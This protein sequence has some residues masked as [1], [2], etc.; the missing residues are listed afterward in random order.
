MVAGSEQNA[1]SGQFSEAERYIKELEDLEDYYFNADKQTKISTIA[2]KA[3]CSVDQALATLLQPSRDVQVKGL[4]LKGRAL[5]FLIGRESESE[6]SLSKAIKLDPKHLASWNALGEVHWNTQNYS[7]ARESFEHALEFCGEN[8]VS[9][10]NLSMVLRALDGGSR[11]DDEATH[12]R[13]AENVALALEKA[14]AA[15]ALDASDPQNWETLGNS[16]VGDFFLNARRPDELSRALIAYSKAE[17]AYE[18]LGK[19]NPSLQLNRGMAARYMEDYDLAL[20][21]FRKAH[22]IGMPS[23]A[24]EGQ[25][26]MELVQRLAGSTQRKGDLKAKRLKELLEDFDRRG[27]VQRTLQDVRTGEGP[28]AAPLAARVVVIIDRNDDL[29]VIVLCCDSNGDFFALSVYNAKQSKVADAIVPMKTLLHIHQPKYREHSVTSSN[30][31]TLSYPCVRVAHPGDVTVVGGGT[32]ASAAVRSKFTAAAFSAGPGA[33]VDVALEAAD[34]LQCEKSETTE[35]KVSPN[36]EKWIDQEDA[37]IKKLEAKA[38]AKAAAKSKPKAKVK[39]NKKDR[40]ASKTI[41]AKSQIKAAVCLDKVEEPESDAELETDAGGS[42]SCYDLDEKDTV[43]CVEDDS[44]DKVEIEDDSSD[45][46]P[47][48]LRWSEL[49]DSEDDGF[50]PVQC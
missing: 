11:E 28:K 20:R 33:A 14:K 47:Q 12:A 30:K 21:S 9:L 45:K 18:K 19:S 38:K 34:F 22:D 5:S 50:I 23:A 13:R 2:E 6:E 44:S 10:R 40:S 4:F 43:E 42:G 15:V 25:K 8:P 26:V 29:P 31:K 36:S 27:E 39:A 46:V 32:L 16:Y 3:L 41:E 48:K 17:T 49:S 37:K 35:A 7:R 1:T 24:A